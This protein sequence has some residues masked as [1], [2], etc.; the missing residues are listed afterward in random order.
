MPPFPIFV[1]V[2]PALQL[3]LENALRPFLPEKALS[4]AVTFLVEHRVQLT[5][6]RGRATKLGDYRHPWQGK[7]HRIS[8]NQ[9]LNRYAFL[10][11]LIHE[12]AHLLVWNAHKNKVKP[13]GDAW[14][15]SFRTL[16]QPLLHAEVFPPELIPVL[17]QYFS[18]PKAS[19]CSDPALMRSLAAYDQRPAHLQLLEDLVPGAHFITRQKRIFKKLEKRRTRI[20]C[21][22]VSTGRHYL[23]HQLAE[24]QVVQNAAR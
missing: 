24:V 2:N 9:T 6:T 20:L 15:N 1:A 23:I 18:S 3:Q 7:G 21:E 22:E 10:I 19:S 5:L 17:Q 12:F 4:Y 11:T 16:M 13:H 14:K 8:V